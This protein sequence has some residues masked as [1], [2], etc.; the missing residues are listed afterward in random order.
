[1]TFPPANADLW[2]PVA[3]QVVALAAA[4]FAYYKATHA[5]HKADNTHIEVVDVKRATGTN[6]RAT[7]ETPEPVK[8]EPVGHFAGAPA[9]RHTDPGNGN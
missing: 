3:S 7:D 1:M 6:R 2:V 8:P 4:V 5:N 9:R